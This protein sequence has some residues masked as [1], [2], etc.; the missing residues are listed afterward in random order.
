MESEGNGV[1]G[2]EAK[3][4]KTDVV[5]VLRKIALVV[6]LAILGVYVVILGASGIRYRRLVKEMGEVLRVVPSE[7]TWQGSEGEKV[8]LGYVKL[9]LGRDA[10]A[11]VVVEGPSVAMQLTGGLTFLFMPPMEGTMADDYLADDKGGKKRVMDAE[12]LGR[13]KRDF[14]WRKDS[15]TVQPKGIF[16][17]LLGMNKDKRRG[18]Q[19]RLQDKAENTLNARGIVIFEADR[20]VGILRRGAANDTKM[21]VQI[22]GKDSGITQSVLIGKGAEPLTVMDEGTLKLALGGAEYLVDE[23]FGGE[24]LER[25]VREA[26]EKLPG[27][28]GPEEEVEEEAE[29]VD[30]SDE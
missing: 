25:L 16:R 6:I 24:E 7:E 14:T 2:Q 8:S 29:D 10:I 13:F 22:W 26:G 15:C 21:M 30:D 18:H 3:A 5:E 27:Y 12:M 20:V 17:F 1:D 11:K 9:G 19:V 23:V 28:V 4:V